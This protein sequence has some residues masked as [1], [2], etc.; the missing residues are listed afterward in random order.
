MWTSVLFCALQVTLLA[1]WMSYFNFIIEVDPKQTNFTIYN[2]I[3]KLCRRN[4]MVR[5]KAN[6]SKPNHDFPLT[7]S[8][9]S[10]SVRYNWHSVKLIFSMLFSERWQTCIVASLPPQ[11]GYRMFPSPPHVPSCPSFYQPWSLLRWWA[12]RVW[13]FMVCHRSR[14]TQCRVFPVGLLVLAT[15]PWRVIRDAALI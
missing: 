3:H 1:L 13:P 12:S 6:F 15:M 8:L 10:A 9:K 5:Y 2:H 4:S 14:V 7:F 11:P